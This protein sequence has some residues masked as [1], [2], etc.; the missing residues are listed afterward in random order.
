MATEFETQILNIDPEKIKTKLRTLGAKEDPEVF[1]KRYIFDID[2]LNEKIPSAGKW[3]RL[4]QAGNRVD[5][6][7]K[8]R[9]GPGINETEEFEVTVSDFSQTAE[10]LSKIPGFTDYYYQENKRT[11]FYLNDCEF[12][13]DVWPLIPPYLEIESSSEDKVQEGLKLLGLEGKDA[14]HIGTISIYKKYGLDLHDHKE[15]KF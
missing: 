3:I 11:K 4:R 15:L 13:L 2:C 9:R 7:Y 1:Q 5:L 6:T 14:G 8:N 12:C 10:I